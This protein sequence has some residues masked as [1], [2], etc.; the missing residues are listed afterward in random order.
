MHLGNEVTP[1]GDV[2]GKIMGE[3]DGSSG[4]PPDNLFE[5]A[6]KI[7]EVLAAN[8]EVRKTKYV[9]RINLLI[10]SGKSVLANNAIE[11]LLNFAL[12]VGIKNHG[13]NEIRNHCV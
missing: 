1:V 2:F 12:D 13:F 9:L 6:F 3:C 11:L 8:K 7:R 5:D 10:Y 4:A